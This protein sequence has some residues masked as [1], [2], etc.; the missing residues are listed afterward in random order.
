MPPPIFRNFISVLEENRLCSGISF[1]RRARSTG[2]TDMRKG[3]HSQ[4]T[5][6]STLF[7]EDYLKGSILKEDHSLRSN[8][9]HLFS[10]HE[11]LHHQLAFLR[12]K[13]YGKSSE[14]LKQGIEDLEPSL[15]CMSCGHEEFP[16]RSNNL[17]RLPSINYIH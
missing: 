13:R 10:E 11:A 17:M 4:S 15:T 12:V 6:C 2:V 9:N 5:L 16:K 1:Q 3:A 14:K 8:Y 7:E